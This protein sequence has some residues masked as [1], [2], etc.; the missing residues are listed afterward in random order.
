MTVTVTINY[1]SKTGNVAVNET[2]MGSSS[3]DFFFRNFMLALK[4]TSFYENIK[5]INSIHIRF[6]QL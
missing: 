4:T 5:T 2:D 3:I 1:I 6:K